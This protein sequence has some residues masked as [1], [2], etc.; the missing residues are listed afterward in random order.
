MPFSLAGV[1]GSGVRTSPVIG[2]CPTPT[3]ASGSTI[4]ASRGSGTGHMA[5]GPAATGRSLLQSTTATAKGRPRAPQTTVEVSGDAASAEKGGGRD[6]V[7]ACATGSGRVTQG[8]PNGHGRTAGHAKHRVQ[9]APT[10][11]TAS[12]TANC[13]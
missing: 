1:F 5:G 13:R 7:A 6:L 10:V 3:A 8:G 11:L 9:H 4:A 12:S 2:R